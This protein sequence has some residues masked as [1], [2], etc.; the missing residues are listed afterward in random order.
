MSIQSIAGL[1]TTMQAGNVENWANKIESGNNKVDPFKN[2]VANDSNGI[3]KS[4]GDFLKD[5]VSS[6]NELQHSAN[7][8]MEKL[9]SGQSQ[10]LHET[11][12]AVE[13]ADLAFKTMNQV[14]SKVIDAYKEIM[15]MQI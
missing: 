13:K 9:A 7:I 14:R 6:V 4:F 1:K 5:S 11:M 2:G 15:K 3:D 10:N 12:L 8:A